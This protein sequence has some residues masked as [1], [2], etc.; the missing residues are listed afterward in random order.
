[1]LGFLNLFLAA[2]FLRAGMEEPE[3]AQVL[4]EESPLAFQFDASGVSW[5][6]HRISQGALD[7]A[8]RDLIVSF[9]SCSF[10]EP[11]EELEALN[12]LEPRV[13]QA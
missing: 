4:E 11:L 7:G 1:M 5:R 3:A 12:L 2:A 13:R 8:R 6:K 9:G 10:T